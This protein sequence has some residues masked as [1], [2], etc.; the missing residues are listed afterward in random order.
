MKWYINFFRCCCS[1]SISICC[2]C[3]FRVLLIVVA[4]TIVVCC[5]CCYCSCNSCCY[6]YKYWHNSH[7][8]FD[9]ITP[10]E[11]FGAA[12]AYLTCV[13]HPPYPPNFVYI[14]GKKVTVRPLS[15]SVLSWWIGVIIPG[16]EREGEK[17]LGWLEM[18]ALHYRGERERGR[19]ERR[20][21]YWRGRRG[22]K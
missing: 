8:I 6:C 21:E 2:N 18:G 4:I 14:V 1:C 5:Y 17:D 15:V 20:R 19:Q 13:C 11:N 7:C 3:C 10:Y 9:L 22:Q 12:H 16:R